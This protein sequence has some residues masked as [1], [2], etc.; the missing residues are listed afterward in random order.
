MREGRG[1]GKNVGRS[2]SSACTLLRCTRIL[3]K[4]GLSQKANGLLTPGEVAKVVT[5][6]WEELL[7][8]P[9]PVKTSKYIGVSW[10]EEANKWRAM[11]SFHAK[12][13]HLGLFEAD[14]E[15]A[16]VAD[17]AMLIIHDGFM[18]DPSRCEGGGLDCDRG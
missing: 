1:G 7:A 6:P 5:M 16:I 2:S 18:R 12:K 10:D 17:R 14:E 13:I 4:L 15:A 11:V 9:K 8:Q 3:H